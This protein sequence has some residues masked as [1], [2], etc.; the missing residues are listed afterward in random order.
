VSNSARLRNDLGQRRRL[1]KG[2]LGR[3]CGLLPKHAGR[4]IITAAAVCREVADV[5]GM[6]SGIIG[7]F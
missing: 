7:G 5:P 2:L 4:T 6:S 3:V 1:W